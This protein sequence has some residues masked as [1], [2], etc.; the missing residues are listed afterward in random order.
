MGHHHEAASREIFEKVTPDEAGDVL[1]PLCKG[2]PKIIEGL[3]PA[4]AG[5]V[6]RGGGG[7]DKGPCHEAAQREII[8]GAPDEAGEVLGPLVERSPPP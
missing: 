1:V 5:E 7:L 8:E 2:A 3:P 6:L 4:E